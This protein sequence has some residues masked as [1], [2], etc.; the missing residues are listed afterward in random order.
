VVLAGK[1]R[2]N[3]MNSIRGNLTEILEG[4]LLSIDPSCGSSSS[5]P[6]YAIYRAGKLTTSG[7]LK[8]N[9]RLPL[10]LR[11]KK[12]YELISGFPDIDVA[13]IEGVPVAARGRGRS[14]IGHAS[15]LQA[16]GV[17]TAAVPTTSVVFLDAR[18]SAGERPAGFVKG[19]EADAIH[20][21]EVVIRY[22]RSE[23][24]NSN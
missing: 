15:L 21:G 7:I 24:E 8:I 2:G 18:I 17:T 11:L 14:A 4:G 5:M 3:L 22:A 19:D 20:L 9:F 6:G 1:I 13:V 23:V 10:V 12:I 16:V